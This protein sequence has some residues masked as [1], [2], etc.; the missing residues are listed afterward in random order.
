MFKQKVI[1]RLIPFLFRTSYIYIM[2]NLLNYICYITLIMYCVLILVCGSCCYFVYD[3]ISSIFNFKGIVELGGE[4]KSSTD[5]KNW[6]VT[7][8]ASACCSGKCTTKVKKW[9]DMGQCPS[10]CTD[11][12]SPLGKK[13][14]CDSGFS[15]TRKEGQPCDTDVACENWTAGKVGS[16]ACCNGKC[17]KQIKNWTG[18][19]YCPADCIG[20]IGG[21]QGSC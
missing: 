1:Y 20:K 3:A 14:S 15:W 16:L 6:E 2:Y 4:C 8:F 21:K 18:L 9:A 5:C 12:P 10:E 7:K 17:Q 19:G 11:A 13:G